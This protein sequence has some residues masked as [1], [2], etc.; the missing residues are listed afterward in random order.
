MTSKELSCWEGFLDFENQKYVVSDLLSEQGPVSSLDCPVIDILEFSLQG[1][2]SN[3]LPLEG[4]STSSSMLPFDP[5]R[6]RD[7]ATC[8]DVTGATQFP[9]L[10]SNIA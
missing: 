9:R 7:E 2:N 6:S 1:M 3:C 4:P 8:W 5:Y 10:S